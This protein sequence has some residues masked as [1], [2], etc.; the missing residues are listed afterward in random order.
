MDKVFAIVV[1]YNG[2]VWIKKCLSSLQNSSIPVHIIVVDNK[3]TDK[4][5]EIIENEYQ[6]VQF[7]KSDKNLGFG[8]G[9]NIGLRIAVKE[10]A[11]YVFLLNQDAWIEK[12]TVSALINVQKTNLEFGILSPLHL[13][14]NKKEIEYYFSTIISP[15]YCPGLIS[16]IYFRETKSVYETRFIHAATWL[17]SKECLMKV[18]G[19]DPLFH[20]YGEDEDYVSR[21]VHFNFKVGIVP[22]AKVFH[23][24]NFDIEKIKTNLDRNIITSLL[25]LKKIN[26]SFRSNFLVYVKA[27]IDELTS[28]LLYR[29][30]KK[31]AFNAK[32]FWKSVV[33]TKK[34]LKSRRDSL[35]EMAFLKV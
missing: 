17:I 23:D 33:L 21:A 19:F 35:K 27:S 25:K 11:D 24:I 32:V 3:S 13:K 5:I 30:F 26:S 22:H 9:N 34:I 7:I 18:G 14:P 8:Q 29:K 20:H 4:T 2:E 12:N 31:F 1:T 16:D 28:N 6:K 15:D 10:N